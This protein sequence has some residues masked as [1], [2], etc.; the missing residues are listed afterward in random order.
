MCIVVIVVVAVAAA[1][2]AQGN[3]VLPG[4]EDP[5]ATVPFTVHTV[6]LVKQCSSNG[7]TVP[8]KNVRMYEL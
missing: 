4:I 1:A 7:Q 2:A 8:L 3:K 5:T 6:S